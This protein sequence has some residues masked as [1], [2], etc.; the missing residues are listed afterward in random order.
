MTPIFGMTYRWTRAGMTYEGKVIGHEPQVRLAALWGDCP[1]GKGLPSV[2]FVSTDKLEICLTAETQAQANAPAKPKGEFQPLPDDFVSVRRP[3]GSRERFAAQ[4]WLEIL[5]RCR[6]LETLVENYKAQTEKEYHHREEKE[7]KLRQEI[8]GL[9]RAVET[10]EWTH[11]SK[12]KEVRDRLTEAQ[13]CIRA[14]V[15]SART[16]T[17][18][19]PPQPTDWTIPSDVLKRCTVLFARSVG[20]KATAVAFEEP[21]ADDA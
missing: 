8:G 5:D 9:Q 12:L 10:R 3:N 1:T 18:S 16:I 14:V 13:D 20:V 11:Q 7:R 6:E 2:H 4:Q 19:I 15:G 21:E 17:S